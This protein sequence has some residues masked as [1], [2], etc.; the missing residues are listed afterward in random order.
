MTQL[1]QSSKSTKKLSV[2]STLTLLKGCDNYLPYMHYRHSFLNVNLYDM[3][4]CQCM[5][6]TVYIRTVSSAF[7]FANPV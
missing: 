1:A 4:D 2:Y 6:G 5:E 3:S 7:Y